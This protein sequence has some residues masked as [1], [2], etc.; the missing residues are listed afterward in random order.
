M[1]TP[2]Q[3]FETQGYKVR[4]E[5][6]RESYNTK[7]EV[8]ITPPGEPEQA[9]GVSPYAK[10]VAAA[11]HWIHEHRLYRIES[12]LKALEDRGGQP[13]DVTKSPLDSDDAYALIRLLEV[14]APAD[15][16]VT[17]LQT[18]LGRI[19]ASA[20][21]SLPFYDRV[22]SVEKKEL[23]QVRGMAEE[24]SKARFDARH[25]ENQGAILLRE[26]DEANAR[27]ERWKKLTLSFIDDVLAGSLSRE[28]WVELVDLMKSHSDRGVE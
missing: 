19:R 6:D 17:D 21:V 11:Y 12:R 25:A 8:F 5:A 24:L 26:R 2:T 28:E 22:N 3:P 27:A 13:A 23:P 15:P 18:K 7:V 4:F 14:F 20:Q 16:L 1:G 10:P 9:I